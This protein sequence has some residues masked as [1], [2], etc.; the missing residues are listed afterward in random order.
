MFD[1][2]NVRRIEQ[3]LSL[4]NKRAIQRNSLTLAQR[5]EIISLLELKQKNSS[6]LQEQLKV[7]QSCISKIWSKREELK[8]RFSSGE[9][10]LGTKRLKSAKIEEIRAELLKWFKDLVDQN[11]TGITEELMLEKSPSYCQVPKFF[12]NTSNKFEC[13]EALEIG[14]NDSFQEAGRR[15]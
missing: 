14:F 5:Y 8:K 9:F 15:S 3:F 1:E 6:Q 13:H 2:L 12:R 11:V 7:S 4:S 10:N